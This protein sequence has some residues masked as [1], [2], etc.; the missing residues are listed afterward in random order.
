MR[1][2]SYTTYPA[3]TISFKYISNL[4]FY[5]SPVKNN[6]KRYIIQKFQGQVNSLPEQNIITS[7]L[8]LQVASVNTY[9]QP[10]Y[11]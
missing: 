7:Y 11:I 6:N 5:V 2:V 9:Y 3:T 4:A 1:I 8:I 10:Y